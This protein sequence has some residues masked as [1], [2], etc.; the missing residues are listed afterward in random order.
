MDKTKTPFLPVQAHRRRSWLVGMA[1]WK[2][3]GF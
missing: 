2:M 1:F 3:R